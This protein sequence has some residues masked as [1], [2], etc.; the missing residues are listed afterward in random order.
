MSFLQLFDENSSTFTYLISDDVTHEAVLID[1]VIDQVERD[2][3]LLQEHELKLKY[4]LETHVHA[5]HVTAGL[6]LKQATG[7]QTA[8][9]QDCHAQGYDFYLKDGD[10]ILFGREELLV[11][12]TPG[13]TPGSVSF[14]WR[15]RVFTG[16]ALLIGGCGRTDFQ[17]GNAE[18]LYRS[19]TE[20]LF[21]LDDQTLVYPA[22][23]YKG[24]RVSSI[25]E[26]KRL[27]PRLA[28][29]TLEEFVSI[30]NNLN[31]PMPKHIQEAVP[32][33]LGG[34][35]G[36]E[37]LSSS[38][39]IPS[40]AAPHPSHHVSVQELAELGEKAKILDVRT[41][42]EF[43]AYHLPGSF[44]IPFEEC[45]PVRVAAVVPKNA[46]LYCL[47]QTGTR[48]Q[49]IAS[50]LQAAGFSNIVHV[51]GGINAWEAAGLPLQRGTKTT[52]SMERQIRL[53]AGGLVLLGLVL[54][55][56]L[57]P[58]A[59]LISAVAG[60]GLFYGGITDNCNLTRLLV[61]MP[62][63]APPGKNPH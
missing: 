42:A 23:D 4:A 24:R 61:K 59:Y 57:H 28:G 49:L 58:L 63:N 6:A 47:C 17:N 54:G 29:K 18:A 26:E 12:A 3:S 8:V 21:S 35:V 15:D 50:R 45:D 51:D 20:K 40:L 43:A 11:L 37:A 55:T 9:A 19:I 5:D 62:W 36:L 31:L 38:A 1:S 13:H 39:E 41:P 25:G 2:L 30:M 10:V 14:L 22:H 48:S 27:N 46:A 44:N 52:M 16:D 56:W 53:T 60:A 34:G 33:N 32:A 7:A